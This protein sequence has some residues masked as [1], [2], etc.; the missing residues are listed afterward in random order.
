MVGTGTMD[1]DTDREELLLR[2]AARESRNE[3]A[4]SAQTETPALGT[5]LGRA[6]LVAAP[7]CPLPRPG[8]MQRA[9]ARLR[10]AMWTYDKPSDKMLFPRLEIILKVISQIF[11]NDLT[12]AMDEPC[13]GALESQ[14]GLQSFLNDE[15]YP[16]CVYL[17]AIRQRLAQHTPE[18]MLRLLK[19]DEY[20]RLSL[21]RILQDH[22]RLCVLAMAHAKGECQGDKFTQEVLA[23]F[24]T[25]EYTACELSLM[26]G[27]EL[28]IPT[29]RD[30]DKL[31]SADDVRIVQAREF[32][33]Q[34]FANNI[35]VSWKTFYAEFEEKGKADIQKAIDQEQ[36]DSEEDAQEPGP[37]DLPGPCSVRFQCIDKEKGLEV[38]IRRLLDLT[39]DG[40]VSLYEYDI[41]TQL[42]QPFSKI[43]QAV[44]LLT[45]DSP[46]FCFPDRYHRVRQALKDT[47]P[48]SYIYTPSR[49]RR[50][51]WDVTYI[52]HN[53]TVRNIQLNGSLSRYLT[54]MQE[55]DGEKRVCRYPGGKS[56][57]PWN[58]NLARFFRDKR[59]IEVTAEMD[60]QYK[61]AG[62]NFGVCKICTERSKDRIL[63]PCTHLICHVCLAKPDR[64]GRI[65][66]PFCKSTIMS[67]EQIILEQR[68][69]EEAD[70]NLGSSIDDDSE[71]QEVDTEKVQRS[72]DGGDDGG[73]PGQ[74][75]DKRDAA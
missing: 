18:M 26:Y 17:S 75:D 21:R 36:V 22:N 45:L 27:Q 7:V 60:A 24:Y 13:R 30:R 38:H 51:K 40:C 12:L 19:E 47:G 59:T 65:R 8:L 2:I 50:G 53:N 68:K 64:R 39:R 29:Q 48:G 32:W 35:L 9:R 46:A 23:I 5:C 16:A 49:S 66:C 58:G 55:V 63:Y 11:P 73:G 14:S 10:P 4:K 57:D 44:I 42:M 33:K 70:W 43:F 52:T 67:C 62:L 54:R 31:M 1:M 74:D 6:L 25:L 72:T 56:Q 3:A 37:V 15:F 61:E 28:G 69:D 34:H 20:L 71:D 41:F